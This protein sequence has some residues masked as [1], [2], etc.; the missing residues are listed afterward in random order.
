MPDYDRPKSRGR[1]LAHEV[2]E[3]RSGRIWSGEDGII[4]EIANP[5]TEETLDDAKENVR[6]VLT[7]ADRKKHHI[8]V[9]LR[10]A[11]FIDRK[12]REYYESEREH[13]GVVSARALLVASPASRVIALS[14]LGFKKPVVLTRVFTSESQAIEW[15][16]GYLPCK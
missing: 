3:T 6:A 13:T 1:K 14:F 15:L 5:N 9:D 8:M 11:K 7:L 4:R 10:K 16:K 2:I 12:A